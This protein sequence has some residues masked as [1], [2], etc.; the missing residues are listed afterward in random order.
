MQPHE[1]PSRASRD[2]KHSSLFNSGR[3]DPIIGRIR[4]D[5]LFVHLYV[6]LQI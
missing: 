3:R 6:T 5:A 4:F 1:T 2:P